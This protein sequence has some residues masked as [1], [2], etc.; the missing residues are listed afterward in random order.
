M[1]LLT[2]ATAVDTFE[3]LPAECRLELTLRL[4]HA[5]G[6]VDVLEN[7]IMELLDIL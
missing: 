7:C 4:Q 5:T 6:R 2:L 1:P 3:V